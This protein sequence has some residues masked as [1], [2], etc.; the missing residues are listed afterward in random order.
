MFMT[1]VLTKLFIFP[2]GKIYIRR[3]HDAMKLTQLI[4]MVALALTGC[5]KDK[6]APETKTAEA[7]QYR[8]AEEAEDI[9]P[10]E[11][12]IPEGFKL[13][14]Q[15]DGDLNKDGLPDRVLIIKA[16]NPDSIVAN[17]HGEKVDRNRRG[18]LVL[19]NRK[20]GYVLAA[21]NKT[22]FSS[23]NE[24]GGVYFPPEMSP[25]IEKG[26][27]FIHYAHGRYGYWSYTFRHKR[28]DFELIG[29]DS[30]DNHGP[31]TNSET[32]M[33]FLTHKKCVSVN[34]N[35]DD[36]DADEKFE[37]HWTALEKLPPM[38]LSAIRDF[39]EISFAAYDPEEE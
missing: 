32:S 38:Q 30:S 5:A 33:N 17:V 1:A 4:W 13:F 11:K 19:F 21:A 16:T 26:K 14:A 34:V 12:F 28:D 23:E 24:E 18:I 3:K 8:Q 27:L 2:I 10:A 36:P 37:E 22:C 35:R 15:T 25:S 7:V 31:V 20:S 6:T 39:D 9:R 29:Y